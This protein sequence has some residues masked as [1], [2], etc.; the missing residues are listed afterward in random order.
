MGGA[1][2]FEID[3]ISGST[4]VILYRVYIVCTPPPFCWG[5]GGLNL[6]PNLR[7]EWLEI[8]VYAMDFG[9]VLFIWTLIMDFVYDLCIYFEWGLFLLNEDKHT[10]NT[11]MVT[12]I[13]I[14]QVANFDIHDESNLAQWCKK[15]KQSFEFYLTASDGQW[16]TDVS[17]TTSLCWARYTGHFYAFRRCW[18]NIQGYNG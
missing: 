4:I 17:I 11:T 15:W 5:G 12:R 2:H 16:F 3:C 7:K 13:N 6:P 8:M 9:W 10:S 14:T 18:Y 1:S